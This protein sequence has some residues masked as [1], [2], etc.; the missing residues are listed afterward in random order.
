MRWLILTS[1]VEGELQVL[2]HAH[3]SGTSPVGLGEKL[4]TDAGEKWTQSA[5]FE[6]YVDFASPTSEVSKL[7]WQVRRE[8]RFVTIYLLM[9]A[10]KVTR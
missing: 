7:L 8:T 10:C 9:S 1:E 3:A 4:D 5:A 2:D 6:A